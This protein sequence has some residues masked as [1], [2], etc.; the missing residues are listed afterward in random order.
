MNNISKLLPAL[1]LALVILLSSISAAFARGPCVHGMGGRTY[2]RSA[3]RPNPHFGQV[4]RYGYGHRYH[5][6][7][8]YRPYYYRYWGWR[9]GYYTPYYDP[10]FGDYD[11]QVI[12]QPPPPPPPQYIYKGGTVVKSYGYIKQADGTMKWGE[13]GKQE[14]SPGAEPKKIER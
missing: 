8:H 9:N 1:G 3:F 2:A 4:R 12:K 7:H 5:P 13:V 6:R 10:Y 14:A 11:D